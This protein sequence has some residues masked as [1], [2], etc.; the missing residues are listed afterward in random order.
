MIPKRIHYC[1]FGG[2]PFPKLVKQCMESWKRFC[3]E[4]EIIRWDESN[5]PLEDNPYVK[6]A[7][8]A[9]KWAFVSDYV[10]LYALVQYGGI[11][12]DTDVELLQSLDQYLDQGGFLGFESAGKVA[13]C[14]MGAVPRHPVFEG[15]AGSYAGRAFLGLDGRFDETT[16]VLSVTQMLSE[17][18]LRPDGTGQTIE[19]ISIY[20]AEYFSPKSL[21]TGKLSLT[22]NTAAIHHFQASWMSPRQRFHTRLAQCLGPN[23]TRNLKMLL[24]RSV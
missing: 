7:Y 22:E 3:P 24:G 15:L 20:P 14:V 5:A 18:G 17:A 19:G 4:F 11:Y 21:E 10:R 1:W 12:L 16:N 9:K 23:I 8:L 6:Q 2:S 13:T